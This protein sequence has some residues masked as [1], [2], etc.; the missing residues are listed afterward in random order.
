MKLIF[1]FFHF[2]C[3]FNKAPVEVMINVT[4]KDDFVFIS[5]YIDIQCR[6]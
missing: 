4:F 6:V 2:P 1:F 3:R 5:G